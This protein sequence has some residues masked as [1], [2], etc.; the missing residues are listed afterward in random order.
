MSLN[1]E[2]RK[3][4]ASVLTENDNLDGE[5]VNDILCAWDAKVNEMSDALVPI[6]GAKA[7]KSRKVST[8]PKRPMSAYLFFCK[9]KRAEV[10]AEF[11]DLKATEVTSELGRMWHEVKET[12]QVE[13]YNDLAK[14]DRARY[15]AEMDNAPPKEPKEKKQRKRKSSTSDSD[16]ESKPK[17]KK[18]KKNGPKKPKSA[19]LYFC[20]EKRAEVKAEN[21]EMKPTEITA[22]LG[23]LWNKIKDTPKAIK[24]KEQAE[25]AKAQYA[26]ATDSAK[27]VEN[28][29]GSG[30]E[31]EEEEKK[32]E[33]PKEKAKTKK[34]KKLPKAKEAK[35]PTT[36]YQLFCNEEG[37]G[38]EKKEL[39]KR[40]F[41]IKRNNIEKF[42]DYEIRAK[43]NSVVNSESD[44]IQ[45]EF[46]TI[47]L[48]RLSMNQTQEPEAKAEPDDEGLEE[49]EEA[50]AMEDE[51]DPALVDT[52]SLLN[53]LDEIK[54]NRPK[55]D[56]FLEQVESLE[57]LSSEIK[58]YID[59]VKKLRASI[60]SITA[61]EKLVVICKDTI[62]SYEL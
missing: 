9:D 44:E 45:E 10:K 36:G 6:V 33:A 29:N 28:S 61:I 31:E 2:Y 59:R 7:K 8:V 30:E 11:P 38:L 1:D 35:V 48:P 51:E 52:R 27:V 25:D 49:E 18:T 22:E 17:K 32:E 19:Y 56:E 23:R 24:Y 15:N 41:E 43:N 4:L 46:E 57:N 5:T 12:E 42:Q 14:A 21:P 50:G 3:M 39:R 34:G 60:I 13:Q 54:S 20:E 40:W 16:G 58:G 47:V 62:K 55:K 26:E 37:E 53:Y